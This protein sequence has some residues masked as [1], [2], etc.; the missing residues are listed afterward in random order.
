MRNVAVT[1]VLAAGVAVSS[2]TSGTGL[3]AAVRPQPGTASM[4]PGNRMTVMRSAAREFGVPVRL[5]LAI[6]YNLTRWERPGGSPSVDGGYGLMDLTAKTF[7]A[8]DWRG[9]QARPAAR[10]ITLARTHDTLSEAARLL[11]VPAMTLR[12][13]ELQNVGGGAAL[14][15]R[16]ARNLSGGNLPV[17]LGGWYGAVAEFSG[18]ASVRSAR[19]FA[20]DMFGTLG[21]GASLTTTDRQVLELPP[22]PHLRPDRAQ[23]SRLALRPAVAAAQPTAVDCP[24]ALRCTFI[25]A[26][27]NMHA[28]NIENEGFAAQGST[29]YSEAM[30]TSGAALV[31]YLAA[32]YGIPLDRAHILGHE[33]V[34]GPTSSLTAAQHWDPGPFW[35]W[36][37]FMAPVHGVSDSGE[38]ARGGSAVRGIHHLVTIDPAFASNMPPVT[39]CQG[40]GC[41]LL[42][43][44]PANFVYLHTGPGGS[45]PLTGDPVLHPGSSGTTADSDWG[46]K[47]A[48]GETF[49][50]AGRK[51]DWTAIWFSG[52]KAWFYDPPGTQRQPGSHMAG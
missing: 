17:S 51:G 8:Q 5:L 20:D 23:L 4:A 43:A 15:A 12:T 39:D 34:P 9:D 30:Y 21:T 52:R 18:A 7:P 36:N 19:S 47:A 32:R 42:P 28:I 25:P 24:R 27:V 45:F 37:H 10:T 35:N 44:R 29:W 49:V 13:S 38:R 31:R 48:T 46:D 33:D 11:H 3:A 41:V 40:R 14:L 16:Y 2:G 1:I 26:A 22:T 50:F 6:S